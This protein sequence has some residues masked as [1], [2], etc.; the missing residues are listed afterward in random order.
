MRVSGTMQSRLN[1]KK[2]LN[3][4]AAFGT[5]GKRKTR[6]E[7]LTMRAVSID[8]AALQCCEVQLSDSFSYYERVLRKN[9]LKIF[10]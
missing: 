10:V 8:V 4:M 5:P 7:G 2:D 3:R 6:S 1:W 9:L